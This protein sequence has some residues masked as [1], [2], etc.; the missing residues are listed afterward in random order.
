MLHINDT[1]LVYEEAFTLTASKN[2]GKLHKA[3]VTLEDRAG[4]VETAPL[5]QQQ[6]TKCSF[7]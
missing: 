4:S 6:G 7:R 3:S 5:D 1:R 2:A